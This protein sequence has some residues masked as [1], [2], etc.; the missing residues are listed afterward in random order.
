MPEMY[1]KYP[2]SMFIIFP[3]ISML[4][5]WGL[6]GYIGGGP[7]GAMIPGA[8]VAL[9]IAMLLQLPASLASIVVVFGVVGIGLGG[10]MTYGQTLGFL[11]N[12]D[13][14]WWGTLGTTVKGSVWGL[15][16]GIILGMGLIYKRLSEWT[17][18]IA[19]LLLLAGMLIGFKLINQPM[20]IYFSDPANPRS[21]SWGALLV[22][23]IALVIYLKSKIRNDDFKII[24]RFAFWGFIGG[25]IG[26]GLGGFWIVLGSYFPDVIFREWWKAMEFS[27]GLILGA[28]LGFAAWLSRG[29]IMRKIVDVPGESIT[30][31]GPVWK[32]LTVIF[33]VGLLIFWLFSFWLDP[34]VEAGNNLRGFSMV[35]LTDV[36][37]LLSN[38]AFFGLIM[39]VVAINYPVV[40]WQIAITLTFCHTVIDLSG[41]LYP[42]TTTEALVSRFVLI[43]VPTLIVGVSTAYIRRGKNVL[44]NLFLLIVWSTVI[45]A[46]LRLT[47]NTEVL[48]VTGLSFCEIVC[49][50]FF[51]HITFTLSALF[52]SWISLSLVV[53]NSRI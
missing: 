53:K 28:A 20:I 17:I 14:M 21:E 23:A 30:D 36:A 4:L 34:V 46:F 2:L 1:K 22:G 29:K 43:F 51:V 19:F 41:D 7:F 49:E 35:S 11:R 32:E 15:L 37:K 13:T 47:V 24:F 25:G 38:Y 33:I 31:S 9:S 40:A 26:F 10:E 42:D 12:P 5:G 27:F 8:M 6:R 45:V 50:K 3:A 44:H 16:G 48:N 18:V 52:V 39:I